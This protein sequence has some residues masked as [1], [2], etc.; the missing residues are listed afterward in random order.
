MAKYLLL[1][2]YRGAPAPV[3]DVPMDQW[4]PEEV[5]A[6]VQYMRDFAARLEE[7]GEFVDSQALAPGG[8]VR[9]L[10]RRGAAAGHRR[11]VRGDQGP[12]R[13]LDGDRRRQ[14]RARARAGRRAVGGPGRG[15]EADPRVARAAPVPGRAADHH[16]VT[17]RWT[18]RCCGSLDPRGDRRPRPS[19]S[20]LRGGRGRRAGRAGRG[21]AGLAGRP[22]ARPEGLAGHRGLAQV[23]RRHPRRAPPAGSARH[24]SRPS[25]APGPAEAA[26][27]HAAALLPV[28]PP[29]ADAGLGRRAHA[30]RGRRPDH[31]SDRAGL[32]G[33]GGDH[34]PADQPGQADRLR[35][36]VRPSP[37]T[38]PPCCACST[39]SSTRATPATSTSPPRRSGSPASWPP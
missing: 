30:A 24:A 23:P 5:S 27:R 28:R 4:T 9:P 10:R 15:R 18:S 21:R 29:V 8:H 12:D 11:P 2:H 14:L 17:H 35:R 22:A 34:G 32:P 26:R 7:T 20:R 39:W 31:P 1:K 6:H 13:R 16:G 25:R 33:A 36:P 37:A 38:S 3:N 19:R